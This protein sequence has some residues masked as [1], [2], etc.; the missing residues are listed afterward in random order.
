MKIKI[1]A[2]IF[3]FDDIGEVMFEEIDDFFSKIE[4]GDVAFTL[5]NPAKLREYSF[6]IPSFYKEL[7]K[8]ESIEDVVVYNIV[9]ISSEIE[10]SKINFAAPIIIN[11]KEKILVQIALDETKYKEF[12]IAE[13]I[14]EYL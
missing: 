4:N 1:V 14:S 10:K 11:K 8:L 3:G 12:G 9:I 13:S 2:P 7:L 5:I 6:E